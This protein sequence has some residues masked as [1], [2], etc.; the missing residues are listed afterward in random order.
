[1]SIVTDWEVSN[2]R[3]KGYQVFE[4][5]ER[6]PIEVRIETR[7]VSV[8]PTLEQ[9]AALLR[10][11]GWLVQAPKPPPVLDGPRR[12]DA[13]PYHAAFLAAV[14]HGSAGQGGVVSA[15]FLMP[16]A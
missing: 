3:A 15:L 1:M 16:L 11:H 6:L 12:T 7:D 8:E 2:L 14:G 9:A 10:E 4:P 13:A 5:G